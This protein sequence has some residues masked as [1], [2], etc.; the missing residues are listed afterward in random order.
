M[1]IDTDAIARDASVS[2]LMLHPDSPVARLRSES[3]Q[4]ATQARF[5]EDRVRPGVRHCLEVLAAIARSVDADRRGRLQVRLYDSMPSIAVYAVDDRAFVSVF[6]HGRLAVH[7]VQLEVQG[8]DSLM[9]RQVFEEVQTLWEIGR[10]FEDL[11]Q[12]ETQL[13]EMAREF[14]VTR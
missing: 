2:I 11:E 7:S 1:R 4:R 12:W 3:L 9:G 14:G 8:R 13:Q 5:R 10:E 6:L